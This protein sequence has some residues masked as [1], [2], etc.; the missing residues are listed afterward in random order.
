MTS[1]I[2]SMKEFLRKQNLKRFF[3][4]NRDPLSS[5]LRKRKMA[6]E[7]FDELDIR[8]ASLERK[9]GILQ[10]DY[11]STSSSSMTCGSSR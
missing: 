6:F 10:N 2:Y 8:M 7:S 3:A 9:C 1:N 11:A 5:C 4:R